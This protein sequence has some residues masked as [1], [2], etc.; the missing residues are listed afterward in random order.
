MS[1]PFR[2]L[3][4]VKKIP[5]RVLIFGVIIVLIGSIFFFTRQTK[6]EPIQ[7]AQVKRQTIVSTIS[8]SGTLTGK[9]SVALKFK[10]G[11][12][13]AYISVKEGDSV[14]KGQT[15]A[16]LDTKD[17]AIA[18]QQARNTWLSKDATAKRVEDDVKDHASDENFTQRE[19][20]I[21]A[22]T[23]RDSAFD[24]IK[25]ALRDFEDA[26]LT[27]PLSGIV[28]QVPVISGQNVSVT[29][30]I[31]QIVDLSEINFEA[32][33]D[34]ADL[35]KISVGQK[36]QASLNS[37][38]DKIFTG[39]VTKI[40]QF[41]KTTSS[42]ATVVVAKIKLDDQSIKFASGLNGQASIITDQK[43]DV[44]TIPLEALKDDNS[45]YV[46]DGKSYKSVTVKTGLKSDTDVEI[47][48]GLTENQQVVTN[49]QAVKVKK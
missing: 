41:T 39:T 22:Q 7:T 31:T 25:A 17:I 37:D 20:R 36:A 5:K 38:P 23:A 33:I 8:A 42:G 10:L 26:T 40:D 12:K 34:E 3:A 2:K 4:V 44:L 21:A 49:P 19:E 9:D 32:E 48:E 43:L 47:L 1:N 29:D 46:L 27:A 15:I 30:T 16:S 11:G 14:T 45:V 6:T 35:P 24:A 13:L 18:L 28:T